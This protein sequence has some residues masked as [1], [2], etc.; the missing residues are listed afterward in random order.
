MHL[1]LSIS[2][3]GSTATVIILSFIVIHCHS[4]IHCN[5]TICLCWL[6]CTC[7]IH[8]TSVRPGRGIPP[9]WLFLRFLP[10][11]F[12]VKGFFVGKFFLTGTEGLR[13]EGVTPCTD[14][15]A[16]W[17]KM[18]F[19][20]LGYTNK[21]WFDNH[22]CLFNYITSSY[23]DFSLFIASVSIPRCKT[24]RIRVIVN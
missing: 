5:C 17:G 14:C 12:P 7:D 23:F 9:L 15:K 19:V 21:I 2:I 20:T 4:I 1:C 24:Y 22:Y 6:F 13:T 18:C 10:H 3:T 11:F 16:L 8:C